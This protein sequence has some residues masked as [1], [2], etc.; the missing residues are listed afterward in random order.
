MSVTVYQLEHSP[1]CIPITRALDALGVSFKT[2]N[3]PNGNREEIIKLTQG[4]YY[5]VPVLVDG[6]KVIFES[7]PVSTDIACYLR[8]ASAVAVRLPAP[9][10]LRA[11]LGSHDQ[12][13]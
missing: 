12:P 5:Q 13:A 11:N 8:I 2:K 9:A 3:V 4:A 6:D 10:G 1:Y 7:S